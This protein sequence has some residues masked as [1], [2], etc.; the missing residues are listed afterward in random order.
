MQYLYQYPDFHGTDGDLLDAGPLAGVAAAAEAASWGGLSFTEHPV[1]SA[2]WLE[3]GGHQTLDPFVA[4]GHV[5]A[6]TGRLRLLTYLG[7]APY[8]NP[9]LLAKASATVDKLSGGRFVLGLGT[10]YLKSEF[11][12][13]GVD[14][15]ERNALFDEALDVLP[16]HW[17]GEPFS[18]KGRHFEIRDAIARPRP[19][20]QPIPIWIGGNARITLRR[21]AERVQ[22][23]MPLVGPPELS[24]T[25][26]TAHISSTEDLASRI[27]ELREMAGGRPIDVAPAYVDPTI[28]S[29]GED[30]ERH[31][32]A[33]GRLEAAGATWIVI[34]GATTS[35][36]ATLEFLEAFGKT[37]IES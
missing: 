1:P 13:L 21:V 27:A 23:W 34:A 20:Q 30:V 32:E 6:V 12:A 18:Y 22:G 17:S 10:G 29:P 7:V 25:A 16:L 4:L 31:R 3:T 2:K 15:D 11:R 37:Y 19:V 36:A 9:S 5:A 14:F 35:E 33:F 26:R 24:V 8:R 28:A